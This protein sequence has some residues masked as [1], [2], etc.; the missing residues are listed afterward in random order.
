[1]QGAAARLKERAELEAALR[2][3]RGRRW[4]YTLQGWRRPDGALWTVAEEVEIDDAFMGFDAER[5]LATE[6]RFRL[7]AAGEITELTVSPPEGYDLIAE[8]ETVSGR[9][10]AAGWK[11]PTI[12]DSVVLE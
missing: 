4:T 11:A 8:R 12:P 6:V 3:G 10:E 2:R 9:E 1:M 5:L 7:D